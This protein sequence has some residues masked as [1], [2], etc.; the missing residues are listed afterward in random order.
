MLLRLIKKAEANAEPNTILS[1][2]A[3]EDFIAG[4]VCCVFLMII[5]IK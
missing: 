2:K 1:E 4:Q 3:V 5:F